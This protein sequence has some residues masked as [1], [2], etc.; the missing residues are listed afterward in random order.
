MKDVAK[1]LEA[2]REKKLKAKEAAQKKKK[3]ATRQ[4]L[5]EIYKS[6]KEAIQREKKELVDKLIGQRQKP[7]Q[8]P[9]K[10]LTEP[11]PNNVGDFNEETL[12]LTREELIE[13]EKRGEGSIRW[14]VFDRLVEETRKWNEEHLKQ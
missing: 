1:Y 5:K 13:A 2:Y 14:D 10:W 9:P 7:Q 11:L 8:K 4:K 6:Q 3:E 12:Y